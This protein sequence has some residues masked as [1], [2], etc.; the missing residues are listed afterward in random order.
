M[1]LLPSFSEKVRGNADILPWPLMRV[2]AQL[3][4]IMAAVRV[5]AIEQRVAFFEYFWPLLPA[6]FLVHALLP[7][8][9]RLPF[10]V[11]TTIG[12]A[13]FIFGATSGAWFLIGAFALIG[14]CH[15]PLSFG[16]RLG[17][18]LAAAA[19]IAAVH[20]HWIPA[21][22]RIGV[23]IPAL[24]AIFMFRLAV[25]L[26]DLQ[27]ER[28]P[29]SIWQRLA[30]F[31]LLPNPIFT[32]FPV[33]DYKTFLRTY[34][35][36]DAAAI[37]Q[38]G[39]LWIGRGVVHLILY[40]L[41]TNHFSPAA[42][43]VTSVGSLA[44]FVVSSYLIYLRMS[45]LF[46]IIAGML[47]IFGFNLP[48][49]HRFYLLASGFND[50]WQRI[51]IYWK[52]LMMKLV[53]YPTFT[54]VKGL[55]MTSGIVIA[56]AAVFLVTWITHAYQ[57]FWMRDDA[58]VPMFEDWNL[59]V[60]D[61]LFWGTF[62]VLVI[63]NSLFSLKRPP[64]AK[65][66][67]KK[68]R[69]WNTGAALRHALQ[70]AAMF[71][72]MCL[73]WSLWQ[74]PGVGSWI[75]VLGQARNAPFSEILWLSGIGTAAVALGVAGQYL[76]HRGI[77]ILPE[78]L[79]ETRAAITVTATMLVLLVLGGLHHRHPFGGM[80]GEVVD[81]MRGLDVRPLAQINQERGYYEGLLS[82]D[83]GYARHLRARVFTERN[84]NER[85]EDFP[86]D[87]EWVR[88][89]D[90]RHK[91]YAPSATGI[92]VGAPWRTNR[93]GM[94]DRDYTK[95]KPDG[96][97]RIAM[98]GAS[99]TMGRGVDEDKDFESQL[100]ELLNVAG[101]ANMPVEILNFATTAY[102]TIENT[103]VCE[104]IVPEFK[105][106]ALFFVAH[107]VDILRCSSKLVNFM[108]DPEVELSYDY[109]RQLKTRAGIDGSL[110]KDENLRR[111]APFGE[112]IL[113]WCYGRMGE[114]CR[115]HG[116]DPVWVFLPTTKRIERAAADIGE[117]APLAERAGFSTLII[118]DPYRGRPYG[119]IVLSEWDAHPNTKAHRGIAL[120][121]LKTLR[122]K[123]GQL[124]LE[125]SLGAAPGLE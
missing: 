123:R 16:K 110:S 114:A 86:N 84:K 29:V 3:L 109:F 95:E 27:H 81:A 56:T 39:V 54:R 55:G 97:Y 88:T 31:F 70:I 75:E 90:L 35:S 120:Q 61:A 87:E 121:F 8:R 67:G 26:Y 58:A 50:Y 34:Y 83:D 41:V 107:G 4:L 33:V 96:V 85:P 94:R 28:Q 60:V 18:I 24:G 89:G 79:S 116:I 42:S 11:L 98:L 122:K 21:T 22:D 13:L 119:D 57:S 91:A 72:L 37:Y 117:I 99:Y 77:E 76:A 124:G 47:V 63:I 49:T 115:E 38:K 80:T 25:Y 12:L 40:R 68:K 112:E 102:S 62:G 71:V 43:E 101:T 59:F 108:T 106:D 2:F 6:A 20:A 113:R 48:E 30:Y 45:G 74:S 53:Y 125:L 118:D 66:L 15:L 73:L 78:H 65:S 46:H 36:Q 7:L 52:D 93:W 19:L 82:A 44:V 14:M 64:A 1:G 100:E 69:A 23:I 51:N 10:F 104:F 92:T 111:I 103:Y 32:L 5:F 17:C 9:W 105:P